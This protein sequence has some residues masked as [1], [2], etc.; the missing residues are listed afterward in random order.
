MRSSNWIIFDMDGTLADIKHRL[1]FI[2][3]PEGLVNG[4]KKN[5]DAFNAAMHD[6]EPKEDIVNLLRS[7]HD[8]D[9]NIAIVT[10]RQE[11]YRKDTES[12]LH[13]NLIPYHM[14]I[15]RATDDMRSDFI[16]KE[17]LYED[18]FT[19]T[20]RKVLF[21]VD[22]RDAVVKMWRRMGLTCLQC[23]EGDY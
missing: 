13:L 20:E 15:M 22:D 3:P 23:Q 5:W 9:Y 6:D 16:I 11:R 10:G 8:M 18:Y 7:M 19:L 21:V 14:L 12:W 17:E 1:H 4:F 2:K